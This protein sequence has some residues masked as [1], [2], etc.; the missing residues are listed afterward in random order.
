[1]AANKEA[2]AIILDV[3]PSM[4]QAPPGA[5]TPLETAIEGINMILQ[6]KIF[7]ESK[8]EI[9][10][11][12]VGTE[13]TD[14]PLADGE[15]Y[16]NI[17]LK[18][19]LGI[20]DFDLLQKVQND[21]QPSNTP[22]DFVDALVVA[23]DHLEQA[24]QGKKGIGSRRII[25]F[26]DLGS[27][28]GDQQ[29]ETI[30]H[31][32][33]N[34]HP[35][36]E[37]NVIGPYIRDEDEDD[38]GDATGR[39]EGADA[40]PDAKTKTPQQ[41]SGEALIKHIID[42]VDGECYSFREALPALSYFQARQIKPMAWKCK[43]EIGNLE[44]PIC[45]FSKIKEYKLKQ[46]WKKVCAQ[47]TDKS[48]ST[49][50][51]H[52]L[53]NEEE[54]EIEK[55][56]MVQGYKY[57]NTIVPMSE[58][59]LANMKYKA[60]KCLKVLGFTKAENVKRH[61]CL[62]DGVLSVTAEKDDEAAAIALS[63]LINAMYETNSVAIARRVYAANS[64]PRIGCLFPHIKAK[65]ECLFWVEL[66]FAEDLRTFT[67]GSLPFSE[68]VAVN[69]KY[70]PTDEQ[71]QAVDSLIDSMDLTDALEDEDGNAEEALKPKSTFNPYFQRVYQCLQ[72]R[73]L[74]PD[75]PLPE[76]SPIVSNY[77][78][79]PAIVL[80]KSKTVLEKLKKCVKLEV[81]DK[82]PKSD[83]N[84][85]VKE[86]DDELSGPPMKKVKIDEDLEGGIQNITKAT[87]TQVGTVNP[88]ED[89]LSLISRRDTDLFEEA[90]DQLQKYIEQ[91]VMQS[92][93]QQ[94]YTKAL[95]C[96]KTLREECIKKLEPNIFN[97]FIKNLKTVLQ[98][99]S[100][101]DFWEIILKE[102]QVLIS[103]LDCEESGVTKEEVDQF[104][105]EDIK[106]EEITRSQMDETTDDLLMEL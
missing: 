10:L 70:K 62:G 58:D 49:L 103:K 87:V 61:H 105:A 29:L 71:L 42:Q 43:L 54:S 20:A 45:G 91:I 35:K 85:F 68:D 44:I 7:S 95:D 82:K 56:D 52:H 55:E 97:S 11:I 2:I 80:R 75:D 24:T 27:P 51:T 104:V 14:N 63:A 12:L 18:S 6:R 59:D 47:N 19:P 77:M 93:G 88:V 90:C 8:D 69:K 5:R 50:R 3:G 65:Y 73:V 67:F 23:M 86:N 64:A 101:K 40:H 17:T 72:H 98:A 83:Q 33:Q 38:S 9:A 100:K 48:P 34:T 60:E 92:F 66:P 37:L 1:M 46:C 36:T 81:V 30:I 25:L 39:G 28:F 22:G 31:A 96:L 79:P 4:N 76:L 106:E 89:F 15:N 21:L 41:R 26:S 74:N 94:N 16:K 99:K 32:M 13:E 78:T 84:V 102:K 57:G 53:D